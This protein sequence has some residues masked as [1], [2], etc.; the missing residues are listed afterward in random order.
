[1]SGG[2]SAPSSPLYTR[3]YLP[4]HFPPNL[5]VDPRRPKHYFAITILAAIVDAL[6]WNN[7]PSVLCGTDKHVM[8]GGRGTRLLG[9]GNVVML[10]T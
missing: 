6:A 4:P 5:A 3:S 8:C 9:E 10:S 2:G 1:M 7:I